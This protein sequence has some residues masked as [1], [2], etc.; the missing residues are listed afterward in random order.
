MKQTSK[1]KIF[2][3]VDESGQD[4]RSKVFVVVALVT[5][6]DITKIRQAVEKVESA[7]GAGFRKWH[8]LTTTRKHKFIRL[9]L[10]QKVAKGDIFYGTYEK[11]IPYFLPMLNVLGKAI[12]LKAPKSYQ[13]NVYVD[14]IDK[15]KARELTN[16]LRV[17][18]V[19]LSHVRS[20]RDESESLIRLVDRWAGCIR[21]SL[22]H[23]NKETDFVKKAQK[24]GYLTDVNN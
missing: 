17:E 9:V 11:P 3:Y 4:A 23:K 5:H 13:A 12:K 2:C 22:E 21:S 8:K 16:A 19:S 18:G 10:E 1:Q 6:E 15:K 20:K 24:Q 7:S 14:G